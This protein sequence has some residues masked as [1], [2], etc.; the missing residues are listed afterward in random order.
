MV[1]LFIM[2]A[3]LVI[4]CLACYV[5][6]AVIVLIYLGWF[7][8]QSYSTSDDIR[9][10]SFWGLP[11]TIYL[12]N[13]V[14]DTDISVDVLEMDN[15]NSVFVTAIADTCSFYTRKTNDTT[16]LGIRVKNECSLG[17]DFGQG[18]TEDTRIVVSVNQEILMFYLLIV[19]FS[20]LML[21]CALFVFHIARKN[22]KAFRN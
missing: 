3:K 17:Q 20:G 21:G 1:K 13:T 4:A 2:L 6:Y 9:L 8:P 10:H 19:F 5:K 22:K 18:L 14:P 7:Y 12:I 15:K 11:N 16:S